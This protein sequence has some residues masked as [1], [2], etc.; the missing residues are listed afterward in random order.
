[1]RW[2]AADWRNKAIAP[3]KCALSLQET[4]GGAFVL[5]ENG[6]KHTERAAARLTRLPKS[7]HS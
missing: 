5:G 7:A 6:R 2:D 1:M 3:Y 4:H